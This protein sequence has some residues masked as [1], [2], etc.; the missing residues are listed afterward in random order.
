[1]DIIGTCW[2]DGSG[3]NVCDPVGDS[4]P[5]PSRF[6]SQGKRIAQALLFFEETLQSFIDDARCAG[7]LVF[8]DSTLTK[9]DLQ[10]SNVGVNVKRIRDAI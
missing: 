3:S 1:M 2:R 7:A 8:E 10:Y 9:M 5:C 6:K 4:V